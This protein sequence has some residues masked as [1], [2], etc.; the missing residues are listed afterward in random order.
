MSHQY[1]N[2]PTPKPAHRNLL[3]W[4]LLLVFI[5]AGIN[6]VINPLFE[7]PDELQHY[8]YVR[9]LVD[10]RKL[11]VQEID[12]P[13]TQS[14]QPPLYYLLGAFLVGSIHDPQTLPE[15]NPFWAYSRADEVS[16]DNKRQF[17]PSAA[18]AFPY[19]G[20]ALVVHILR[21]GSVLMALGST[22]AI[23]LLA[24][25]LWP[26][27]NGRIMLMLAISVLNPMFLY[28]AGAVNNDNLIIML[29]AVLLWVVAAR[30]IPG[31]F[32]WGD[33]VWLGWIWGAALLAKL[34]GLALASAWGTAL[35]LTAWNK[36]DARFFFSRL[37]VISGLALIVSGWW[38]AHNW[39]VYGEPFALETMLSVWGS[40][41]PM[42]VNLAN[43]WGD[44]TYAWTNLWGRFG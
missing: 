44:V 1:F 20:A 15:R 12:G 4:W 32:K 28:M 35:L 21:F 27:N 30:A 10:E 36:R 25:Y 26:G 38:F 37:L 40:R 39:Q 31:E 43:F 16:P 17:I 33:T 7:P 2:L 42:D 8:Q 3:G 9:Y 23:W 6:S 22:I 19:A 11:P 41:P 29:G 24:S 34:S 18:D 13:I 14:H 5:L